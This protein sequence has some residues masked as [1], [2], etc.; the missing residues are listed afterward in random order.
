M[1]VVYFEKNGFRIITALNGRTHQ[2]VAAEAAIDDVGDLEAVVKQSDLILSILPHNM[3][4]NWQKISIIIVAVIQI[5]SFNA[6]SPAT[7]SNIAQQFDN[8]PSFIDGSIIGL[9]QSKRMS[10]HAYMSVGISLI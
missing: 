5:L 10:E 8:M 7:V 9:N 3:L 1:P 6:I 2:M 4:I